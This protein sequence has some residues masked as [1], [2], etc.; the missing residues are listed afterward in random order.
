MGVVA[1]VVNSEGNSF[2]VA[3]NSEHED[4]KLGP[5]VFNFRG[6]TNGLEY[7]Y[8]SRFGVPDS[9]SYLF[10][11]QDVPER[12]MFDAISDHF[13]FHRSRG[14]T[15]GL[16]YTYSSPSAYT[17]DQGLSSTRGKHREIPCFRG[18]ASVYRD[19]VS[20]IL[21]GVVTKLTSSLPENIKFPVQQGTLPY[22]RHIPDF[23]TY[24]PLSDRVRKGLRLVFEISTLSRAL[25]PKCE[26][27]RKRYYKLG[28]RPKTMNSQGRAIRRAT[29]GIV[30]SSYTADVPL[31]EFSG[32]SI[33]DLAVRAMACPL[34]VQVEITENGKCTAVQGFG[35]AI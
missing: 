17:A 5:V 26:N 22:D 25:V 23:P 31:A 7:T 14:F 27:R 3:D 1:I 15:S 24:P 34:A 29:I 12:S 30:P 6:L 16:E 4:S 10:S 11:D 8:S 13:G 32:G 35:E 33:E 21:T 2:G 18:K 19:R 20:L 28:G 9:A